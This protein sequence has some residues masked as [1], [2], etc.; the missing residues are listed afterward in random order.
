MGEQKEPCNKRIKQA[1]ELRGMKQTDLVEA[2]GIGKSAIS[3]YLSG[4]YVPK[5]TA[6][7]LIAKALNVSEAWLMGYDVPIER[8]EEVKRVVTKEEQELLNM[9]HKLDAHD[10]QELF[11]W[12]DYRL[13]DDKYTVKKESLNAQEK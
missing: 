9:F 5:Q 7:H 2:T 3:Q 4:K 10:K 12:I 11:K 1:L 6:T 8:I 13:T